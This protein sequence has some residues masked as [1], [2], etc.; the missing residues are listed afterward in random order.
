[1]RRY[2]GGPLGALVRRRPARATFYYHSDPLGSV[3]DVTDAGGAAQWRYAYEPFG[4]ERSATNV[5]GSAPANRLRFTGQ[6][7]DPETGH[8]HLR[9][10]QY[11]PA[12]GRFGALD[13][14]ESPF[15][16]PTPA[17]TSTSRGARQRSSTRSG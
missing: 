4:A 2:L 15:G 13:P 3:T 14:V 9:A 10:R 1:M 11:D 8:Y 17:P 16:S 5:S 6:Y 7:L 12:T